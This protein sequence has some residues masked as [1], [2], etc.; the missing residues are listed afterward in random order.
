MKENHS[1][2]TF[3][4]VR[5]IDHTNYYPHVSAMQS[6][7]MDDAL[8]ISVGE[9][10]SPPTARV[11]VHDKTVVLGIP[12]GR[13]PHLKA[14]TDYLEQHDYDVIIRNSG[15]LAVVLDEG[16]LNLSLIFPHG[17][18]IDIHDGYEAMVSL[19]QQL[20]KKE[21][22]KIEAFEVKGSYCPG[23]YDLSIDG[24]KFAGISQRRVKNGTAVQ[25]YICVEGSGSE[26]AALVKAFYERGL[27]GDSASFS[28]PQI[29]PQSMASL[30]ELFGTTITVSEVRNRVLFTLQE[31]AG[32]IMTEPFIE[33]EFEWFEKR[34][35]QMKQRNERFL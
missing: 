30:Q 23:D 31:L 10:I 15:G 12:D 13:L 19:V 32:E 26:R 25:I 11:W 16:I 7:A 1:L 18:K 34:L 24:M 27:Q 33:E 22:K 6:F 14:G 21:D 4:K 9:A 35:E 28:Y 20:F 3:S 29:T 17:K 8:C 2:L 5:F